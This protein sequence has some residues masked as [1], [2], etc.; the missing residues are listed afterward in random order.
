MD[1]NSLTNFR[2]I[3]IKIGKSE[4]FPSWFS[5]IWYLDIWYIFLDKYLYFSH[6][7]L[8]NNVGRRHFDITGKKLHT[9]S[10]RLF[11]LTHW[12]FEIST[13]TPS[14]SRCMF[15]DQLSSID[16]HF[17][18][19]YRSSWSQSLPWRRIVEI[20]LLEWRRGETSHIRNCVI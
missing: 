19:T 11:I 3:S 7:L 1:F 6:D 10:K 15:V 5:K 18:A 9:F 20:V 16:G 4:Y 8:L 17:W 12:V 2:V 14:L 13:R